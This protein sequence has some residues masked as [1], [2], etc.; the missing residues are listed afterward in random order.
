MTAT[1]VKPTKTGIFRRIFWHNRC[2][3]SRCSRNI[4]PN[5]RI[6]HAIYRILPPMGSSSRRSLLIPY[7]LSFAK[8]GECC[9]LGLLLKLS[10]PC[11]VSCRPPLTITRVIHRNL[12]S[13]YRFLGPECRILNLRATTR[14]STCGNE[15]RSGKPE[16]SPRGLSGTADPVRPASGYRKPRPKRAKFE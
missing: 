6:I 12:Q 14:R 15:R 2:I 13:E 4:A 3:F 1:F 7:P 10:Q 11:L 8:D 5:C 9:K 16:T